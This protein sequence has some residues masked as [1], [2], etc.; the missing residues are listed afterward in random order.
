MAD[1]PLDRYRDQRD[2]GATPEPFTTGVLRPGL[3]V[4]HQHHA[5]RL[6]FDLRLELSG[7]LKSW[8]VPKGPSYVLADKRL[9]ILVEDHPLDYGDFEGIIPPGNYGAGSTI[10]WD[11]GQWL[12]IEDPVAG[13]ARGKLLF[14]L[15]GYKL[16]GRWTLVRTQRSPKDWLLI[17]ERDAWEGSHNQVLLTPESVLSGL[18]VDE[19]RTGSQRLAALRA[20]VAQSGAPQRAVVADA[21][22]LMLATTAERPFS[23]PEWL[24]ELK[25]DG[26]R[27]LLTRAGGRPQVMLRGGGDATRTFPEVARALQALPCQDAVLD[28]EL[29]VLAADG[30]ASF[31]G[32]QQR[33]HLDRPADCERAAVTQPVTCF[34]FDLW[35]LDG[36]DLRP[37]PLRQR[38]EFLRQL[39]PRAG[40]LRYLDH[41]DGQGEALYAEV[42]RL[43]L[44]GLLAKR[45]DA[46]Y[47]AGRS[48][49]WLKLRVDRS[50][51]FVVVG[52][53]RPKGTRAGLGALQ[54][55]AQVAGG[56]RY[57]GSVGSGFTDAELRSLREELEP[58][59]VA[60]PP[61]TGELPQGPDQHWVTPQLV[62]EVRFKEWTHDGHLRHPVFLRLRRDKSVASCVDAPPAP[63]P[64]PPVAA[65]AAPP[66][67]APAG[68]R[69]VRFTNRSKVLWPEHGYTKGDLID[70][71]RAVAPA[72]L[73]LLR[74]R[75]LVLT[76]FPDGIHGKNFFQKDAPGHTPDWVR[77][78]RVFSEERQREIDYF[79]CEDLDT[80]LFLANL[81]TI[82][83]HVWSSRIESAQHPDWC[84]LDLDPKGAPFAHVI[85][86][87]RA[88]GELCQQLGLPAFLKTS[89][90][91]GLH[92]L[93]PLGAQLNHLQ[94][95]MLGELL[96]RVLVQRLPDIATITRAVEAR[97]GK[98]YV[99]YL[100]NGHGKLI[101]SA[102]CVRP[103]PGAPVSTP[104]LWD[105][106][107]DDLDP[108]QF[109][110]RTVPPRLRAQTRDP[111]A[112]LLELRPDIARALAA[113]QDALR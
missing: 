60:T 67:T 82:P 36:F 10:V 45:A 69:V 27:A 56:L 54:L 91:T 51:D 71:Y 5:S 85:R 108:G 112:Q 50:G 52:F 86:V 32:L 43:G 63:T 93:L 94:S 16:R 28:G 48:P 11:R 107:T 104:L 75:P 99:D 103:R 66:A 74:S 47:R 84:I 55:A 18:T 87:A 81:A 6:H 19:L 40:A 95:R 33:A 1:Q 61:C 31:H 68:P 23:S 41:I 38:K 97:G 8:A 102:Y 78:W 58:H 17:K 35:A 70:Y 7:T 29:V 49:H 22:G 13:L 101:A 4:V 21:R 53:T 34:C 79:L 39:L 113:L 3:F 30:R 100:Q 109:T 73:P 14:E 57:A 12:P 83:L 25:Q 59:T 92:V 90:G 37:L 106:L 42:A 72:L 77:T 65:I 111:L 76:R 105:E 62:C 20:A 110:L 98:V 26:F 64:P 46:P 15:R 88:A 9:A 96:A 80:L 44:E 2:P 24:F 89:G